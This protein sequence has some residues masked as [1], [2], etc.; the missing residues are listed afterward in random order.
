MVSIGGA[1]EIEISGIITGEY[2]IVEMKKTQGVQHQ[3]TCKKK[4]S[5]QATE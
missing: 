1:G 3:S 4:G 5:G 2:G